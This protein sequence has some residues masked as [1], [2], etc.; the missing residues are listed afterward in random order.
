MQLVE[1]SPPTLSPLLPYSNSA[2]VEPVCEDGG[3]VGGIGGT[4]TQCNQND[5][6]FAVEYLKC[7]LIT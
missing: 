3:R 7:Q 4:G 6:L 2:G 1:I 5:T